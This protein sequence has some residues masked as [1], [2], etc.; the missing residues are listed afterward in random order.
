MKIKLHYQILIALILGIIAGLVGGETCVPWYEWMGQVFLRL[1][2]MLVIPL[3]FSSVATGV[4]R[5]GGVRSAGKM[6][7]ATII[8]YLCTSLLAILTGLMFVN[9]IKPG[10]G[11]DLGQA[12]SASVETG[13]FSLKEFIF[14]MVPENPIR[15]AVGSGPD[16]SGN[17]NMLGIIFFAIIVGLALNALK[18]EHC[19]RLTGLLDAVFHLMMKITGWVIRLAPFGVFALMGSIVARLGISTLSSLATYMVTVALGLGFHALI[20]L[21]LILF[22]LARRSPWHFFRAISPALATAFSTASSNAALPLTIENVTANAGVPK[23]VGSFVLPVGATV[24]MDGTALYE[25]VAAV[26][27]AQAMGVDLSFTDQ[28]V[29][30]ITAL[31]ASVGAAGI[32]HAGLVMMAVVLSAVGLPLEGLGIIL[33]VDSILDMM[34]T[35]VN[36]WSD[37]IGSAFVARITGE[38]D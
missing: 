25:C 1:L 24:N 15:D 35:T 27:I 6:G 33:A 21:C 22:F 36:V 19:E 14:R 16:L 32:P 5:T 17:P 18:K 20:S 2:K 9:I 12:A 38:S 23:K 7:V 30:V 26:F 11:M 34:R 10:D 8:Y 29:V 3:I 31:A 28:A 37:S 4:A 13:S